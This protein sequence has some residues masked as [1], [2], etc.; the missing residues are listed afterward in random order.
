MMPSKIFKVYYL[1]EYSFGRT[2]QAWP[3]LRY[4]ASS[5]NAASTHGFPAKGMTRNQRCAQSASRL[6]GIR[7]ASRTVKRQS[8]A[9]TGLY[10]CMSTMTMIKSFEQ[11]TITVTVCARLIRVTEASFLGFYLGKIE[12]LGSINNFVDYQQRNKNA[13]FG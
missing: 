2:I 5:A 4:R 3:K 6:T 13:H 1:T 11:R 8:G 12:S 10:A 9:E 7:R